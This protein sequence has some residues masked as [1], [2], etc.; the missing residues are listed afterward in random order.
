MNRLVAPIVLSLC[1]HA[2]A[3]DLFP[4]VLPWDD[5]GPGITDLSGWMAKPAGAGGVIASRDGHF[6]SGGKRIRFFGVNMVG[7]GAFPR[8]EDAGKI[9]GRLAK[10]GVNVVR[11]HHMD[12]GWSPLIAY[13][14]GNSRELD[15]GV[16]DRLDYLIAELKVRGIYSNINLLVGREFKAA[17]GL[18]PEIGQLGP[19]EQHVAGFFHAPLLELQK[20]SARQLLGHRN[21]YTGLTAAEDPAVA[22]V[23][24]NNENGLIHA[25]LGGEVDK[26]PEVFRRDLQRQWNLWLRARYGPTA[27]LRKAWDVSAEPL[28][29]E[30]LSPE[31][32]R[33]FLE[34][35]AGATADIRD[36]CITVGKAGTAGWHVQYNQSGIRLQAGR[37]YTLRFRAKAD[38]PCDI[39]VNVGEA[40]AGWRLLGLSE[41]AGL[42]G[43]WR[44]FRFT[45][46]AAHS[47]DNARVSFTELAKRTGQYW[48]ADISLRP[49]GV[50]GLGEG[51]EIEAG[52]VPV[53]T[54]GRIG[55]RSAAAQS[56]WMRFLWDTEDRYWQTMSRFLKEDLKFRG[57]VMGTIVGCST[58]NLMA[59]F[60]A[61]DTHAY[62][63]HPEFPGRPWD[64]GNWIVGN[65]SMVSERD[66]G[67]LPG[68]AL[69]RV[70]GKPHCVTEY[71]HP[72]PN[73]F[74]S[75]GFLLL[76][77]FAAMQDWD[78][79]YAYDYCSRKD[80]LDERRIPNFFDIDQHPAKMVTLPPA[81]AMFVR[82]DVRP[83]RALTVVSLGRDREIALLPASRPWSLVSAGEAGVPAQEAL[84][85]RVAIA[86]EG[87]AAAPEKSAAG[88]EPAEFVWTPG[89][90]TVNSRRSKAVI[91]F[92]GGKKIDLGGV[93]IEPGPTAQEGW[94]AI[95]ATEMLPG[96][97]L[98]TAT[99][100]SENTGMGWKNAARTT[101]GRD[102]GSPPSLVEGIAAGIRIP[103][104]AKAWSLDE[105]GRRRTGVT[106]RDGVVGI[107]P[108]FQTLW[109]EV[110]T[111]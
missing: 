73:T 2:N 77:A 76:A 88:D 86:T 48:I 68:L 109:Y 93:V 50:S 4:F 20:E 90:V 97:W 82:G 57:V 89:L 8:H 54:R 110:Q 25:W 75:E 95:T 101:V 65:K 9:A 40:H 42:S 35:H 1:L 60:D 100:L 85:R 27:Q 34:Q 98:I 104:A 108:E 43:E 10:F 44:E 29:A 63:Q 83:A 102:W 92:A 52:S 70:A 51:E 24:I 39:N 16:L 111:R 94:C 31:A 91:G 96:R 55:S 3:A 80:G 15:A 30:M 19:K 18:A 58:P 7:P 87:S 12:S 74:S 107:G 99:G 46:N 67:T 23:E 78:A 84:R 11:L 79:I 5:A 41:T 71:N 36:G 47:D 28:G 26:L 22:F 17:D 37:A 14:K 32:G 106:L 53:F 72:A 105:L 81:A 62:W 103:G 61:V 59:H 33:W 56:D 69:R 38:K 64:P 21:P 66:G 45:F 13:S 6:F 49:G